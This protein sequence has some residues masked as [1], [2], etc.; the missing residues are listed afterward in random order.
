MAMGVVAGLSGCGASFDSQVANDR[1]IKLIKQDPMFS[2]R[3]P[4]NLQRNVSYTPLSPPPM[5]SQHSVVVVI[6]SVPDPATIPALVTLAEDASLSNG[7][8][9]AGE[10]DAGGATIWL[11]IQAAATAQGVSLIF[12]SPED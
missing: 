8:N 10:R 9:R 3:P 1:Y 12:K 6:Y 2:W 5:A 7:Y 11:S 4:G